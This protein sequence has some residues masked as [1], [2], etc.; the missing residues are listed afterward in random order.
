MTVKLSPNAEKVL[1]RR[2]LKKGQAGKVVESPD[3][4]FW[5]VAQAIAS[6]EK[7]Y[8]KDAK[9]SRSW[10]GNFIM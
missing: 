10:Q 2:Y 8:T 7:G 5:R 6:A 3:Q 9:R 4:L 1:E